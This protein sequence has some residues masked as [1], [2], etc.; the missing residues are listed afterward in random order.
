MPRKSIT[1]S[2]KPTGSTSS[3]NDGKRKEANN[4]NQPPAKKHKGDNEDQNIWNPEKE[5]YINLKI[6]DAYLNTEQ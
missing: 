6:V 3:T 5:H 2:S 4:K 1:S